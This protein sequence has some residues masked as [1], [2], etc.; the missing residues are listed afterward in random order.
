M[1][2]VDL[3]QRSLFR[4][5]VLLH[6]CADLGETSP[7]FKIFRIALVAVGIFRLVP[8]TC[9]WSANDENTSCGM[10]TYFS[11]FEKA[12]K[13][14]MCFLGRSTIM[15]TTVPVSVCRTEFGT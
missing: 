11:P 5:N 7:S 10:G 3:V 9:K 15:D 1:L 4:K 2:T 12:M 8:V 6:L 13:V 14:V